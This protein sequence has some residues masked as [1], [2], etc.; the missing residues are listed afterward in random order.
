[1][2]Q[3][4]TREVHRR[5]YAHDASHYL[6]YP[7]EVWIARDLSDV[8]AAMRS[9]TER[10]LPVTFR[11]GGTSLSG[12]GVGEGILVDV[13]RSFTRIRVHDE[14]RR[15]QVEPGLTV[16]HVNAVLA[17]RGY[18][19][20]PDPASEI[21]ATI[22]GVVANNSSGM[23]CGVKNNAYHLLED[24]VFVLPSGTVID[25]SEPDAEDR[26]RCAEPEICA[27]LEDIR[28]RLRADER[29]AEVVATQFA[30]KNTMGY[31]L[32]AFLDYSSPLEIFTH[33]LVGSEGTLAFIAEVTMRTVPRYPQRA[34]ALVIFDTLDAAARAIPAL[35]AADVH[36][37]E[38]M[39]ARSL[40][41]AQ[42]FSQVPDA[43]RAVDV[44]EHCALLIECRGS[45]EAE[46]ANAVEAAQQAL[47]EHDVAAEF[48]RDDDVCASLWNVRKGLYAACAGARKAGTTA[49]LEDV[50]VPV[51]SLA[52][53]TRE[54]SELFDRFGYDDAVIFGHAK[55]GNLH[56]MITDDFT[57][58][59]ARGRLADFTD[60]MVDVILRHGGNL[61]AEHGTG[62]AM[63]P[64]V[65]AQYGET[66]YGLMRELKDAID[67]A[68]ILNPGVILTTRADSHLTDFKDPISI[69]PVVDRCVECGYCEPKCPSKDLTL[70]PRT[71]IAVLREIAAAEV[72]GDKK[73]AQ[74][75]IDA[76]EYQGVE[77]CAVDGMCETACPLDIN[78][79]DLVRDLRTAQGAVWPA[80]WSFAS[81]G[82]GA[83]TRAGSVGL[84]VAAKLP[85]ALLRGA[86]T[87]GRAVFGRDRIPQWSRDIPAG[88][89]PRRRPPVANPDA[90]YF[91]S[92]LGAMFDSGRDTSLQEDLE[93]LCARAGITLAVPEGIDAACCGTPWSS[94]GMTRGYDAMKNRVMPMLEAAT[95]GGQLPVVCDAS[96][97]TEGLMKLLAERG[98]RFI[99][100]P[101]FLQDHVLP[102]L[103]LPAAALDSLTLHPTCSSTRIG[104]VPA[105]LAV[106]EALAREVRVPDAW[107]CCAFAGDRGLLHPELTESATRAEAAEVRALGSQAHASANRTCE[108]GMSRAT[109]KPYVGIV[110][111]LADA[112][113]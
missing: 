32:N 108:I 45:D 42:G 100:A 31:G 101:Q 66:L 17:R 111:L 23:A 25:T 9:A 72:R 103:D 11:A 65:K 94:K 26:F 51:A 105:T 48:S 52:D 73:T 46:L 47:A 95:R 76:Y 37:A 10:G 7:Q 39:D 78:T 99:D 87:L 77:T 82:W 91:P 61:K 92:C 93:L 67:P 88:G 28:D 74:D 38:L 90:V 34:A 16:R 62:R 64:F 30:M 85:D 27:T 54:L 3:V 53:A 21:A 69:H 36:T 84:S 79:G 83:V 24:A 113:R 81:R 70:T 96:S 102:R 98:I 104:S 68:G 55:D 59:A 60:G 107:G 109:G 1:M 41:V 19:L 29:A 89:T 63:A 35:T 49:L 40:R 110:Q 14:G 44:A 18:S 13:R 106:G 2:S 4:L 80:A 50:V 86:T 6:L 33:L 8:A 20:G 15:V 5:A 57:A 112:V 56:F 43:I 97:C 58:E 71:R 12:Q 22:G 75:L